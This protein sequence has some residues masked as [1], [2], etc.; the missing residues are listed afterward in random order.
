MKAA[1]FAIL[2]AT[3]VSKFSYADN[4]SSINRDEYL[5]IGNHDEIDTSD[6]ISAK[7]V[8]GLMIDTLIKKKLRGG[9]APKETKATKNNEKLS[10]LTDGNKMSKNLGIKQALAG[11]W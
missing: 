4:L 3:F 8:K 2:L 7:I 5:T 6:E 11:L 9:K 1:I 10:K